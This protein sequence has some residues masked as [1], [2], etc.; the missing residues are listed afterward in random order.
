LIHSLDTVALAQE[1]HRQGEKQEKIVRAL[2]EVNLGGEP[3]KSGIAPAQIE[4]LLEAVSTLPSLRV[5]GFMTIPPPGPDAEAS[6]P[7]FQELARLR[8]RYSCFHSANITLR[9]LSMGMTDDYQVAIEE[10][11]T[12]VRIGRAIFGERQ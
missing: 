8:E 2:I 4:P 11:A 7:Y 9:E 6:R 1:L 10:G 12:I 5:Q 3:T